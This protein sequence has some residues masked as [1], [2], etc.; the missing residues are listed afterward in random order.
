M[1]FQDEILRVSYVFYYII[2]FIQI[3]R[4]FYNIALH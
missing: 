4:Y 1:L 3:K 2:F